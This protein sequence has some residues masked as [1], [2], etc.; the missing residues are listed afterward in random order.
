MQYK[1]CEN[2]NAEISS[3]AII[4]PY[5]GCDLKEEKTSDTFFRE[6]SKNSYNFYISKRFIKKAAIGLICSIVTLL[7]ISLAISYHN[8][9]DLTRCIDISVIGY[10]GYAYSLY[11]IN[12]QLLKTE[13]QSASHNSE[14]PYEYTE[15]FDQIVAL[16]ENSIEKSG[17]WEQLQ[18]GDEFSIIIDNLQELSNRTGIKFKNKSKITHTV[19]NLQTPK[20]IPLEDVFSPMFYGRNGSGCVQ[21][22]IDSNKVPFDVYAEDGKIFIDHIP[23]EYETSGN[24]GK[25]SDNDILSLSF[26]KSAQAFS[27]IINTYGCG[28]DEDKV[29]Y[30]VYGLD[31]SPVIDL[32]SSLNIIFY[33]VSG[34]A[35]M[36]VQW[37]EDSIITDH[38]KI[39]PSNYDDD[40]NGYFSIYS[41][42]DLSKS[43]SFKKKSQT[44]D[45]D[46]YDYYI[47]DYA[48][49]S[50]I[51][52]NLCG[53]QIITIGICSED[54]T[55]ISDDSFE[56]LGFQILP[57][58]KQ[59]TV[60]GSKLAHYIT[61]VDQI[62][63][64]MIIK[65][66]SNKLSDVKDYLWDNWSFITRGNDKYIV[67][68]EFNIKNCTLNKKA[69]FGKKDSSENEYCLWLVYA[70]TLYDDEMSEDKTVF[71][72]A[73][74]DS[75]QL[76]PAGTEIANYEKPSFD[77]LLS[78][79]EL[80]IIY[81][82]FDHPENVFC[83]IQL[84]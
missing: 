55:I 53:G 35:E 68:S 40:Y 80:A 25:L 56:Q 61:S 12:T 65:Y 34:D 63:R 84:D 67:L 48:V 58:T 70:C 36:D 69:Y 16:I 27:D 33:G 20:I 44:N 49:Y 11:T 22:I 21:F 43:L 14:Q 64:D 28:F 60:D 46:E 52:S 3:L 30:K 8:R 38:Y 83:E 7:S 41:N 75:L 73:T 47:G 10:N 78:E 19:S 76:N 26:Q 57:C 82:A 62:D 9:P 45:I 66:A 29:E 39:V 51:M 5:C 31:D 15:Q 17:K 13:I 54:G 18:N 74:I 4:C 37:K 32:F 6:D 1:K 71:V 42:L 77:F 72:I 59:E 81:D 50:E 23:F 2:C 79:Q 24:E